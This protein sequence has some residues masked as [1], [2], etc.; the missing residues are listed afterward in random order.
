MKKIYKSIYALSLICFLFT[1]AQSQLIFR[2]DFDY[3]VGNLEGKNGGTGFTTAWSKTG[4]NAAASIGADTKAQILTG[5][6]AATG[7][8]GNRAQF[9]VEDGKTVR[10]DRTIP[11]TMNGAK[12]TNYWVGFW[13]K[14][15][16]DT[17]ANTVPIAAQVMFLSKPATSDATTQRLMIGKHAVGGVVNSLHI[18][19]RSESCTATAA[20]GAARAW[21]SGLN[22]KGTY[23]MLTKI[24]KED[25]VDAAGVKFDIVRTW[26]LSA[27]PANEA[28]LATTPNGNTPIGKAA[29]RSLRADNNSFCSADGITGV[30]IRIE[31][32]AATGNPAYCVEFDDLRV[33]TSL[34]SVLNNSTPVKEV[35]RDYFSFEL[36]PNPAQNR[37]IVNLNILKAGNIDVNLMDM[38]GKTVANIANG[39]YAEGEHS[40]E[41]NT[42]DVSAGI[43]FVKLQMENGV[44]Q[45]TKLI[46]SK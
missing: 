16:A 27:P 15:T 35:A 1:N 19:S 10:L 21:G 32:G 36:S 39:F 28:A 2:E 13:Y 34:V 24:T 12:G 45:T 7:G 44:Q 4:T 3:P 14:S 9:C 8:V 25:S 37:S 42:Q 29:I 41:V 46:V 23:Y 31:S 33:G 40:L 43:Y 18:A 26:I 38:T 20:G 11:L 30:R 17:A 22:P 6:I 5:S